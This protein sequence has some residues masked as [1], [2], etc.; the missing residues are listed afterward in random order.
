VSDRAPHGKPRHVG[1][2]DAG[3]GVVLAVFGGPEDRLRKTGGADK[4]P[5]EREG[6]RWLDTRYLRSRLTRAQGRT[7][8]ELTAVEARKKKKTNKQSE[9]KEK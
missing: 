5:R 9:R 2:G 7:A 1:G 8:E 3:I 4:G 6:E